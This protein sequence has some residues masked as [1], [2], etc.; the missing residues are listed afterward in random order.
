MDD[1]VE[2]VECHQ[3]R[4]NL[5]LAHGY[6][7]INS[8]V[9]THERQRKDNQQVFISREF[10]YVLSRTRDVEVYVPEPSAPVAS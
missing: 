9:T 3:K 4:A 2:V 8:G 5:Y 10:Q 7:L 6:Q 1:I